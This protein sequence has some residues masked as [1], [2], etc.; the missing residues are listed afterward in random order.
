LEIRRRQKD[1]RGAAA[2]LADE[3][4]RTPSEEGFAQCK[5]AAEKLKL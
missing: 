1:R 5:K 3:F 4:V 2:L